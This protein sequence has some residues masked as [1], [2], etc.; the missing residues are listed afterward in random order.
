MEPL[1]PA[2]SRFQAWA[3]ATAGLHALMRGASYLAVEASAE[4][5]PIL[6]RLGFMPLSTLA[7]YEKHID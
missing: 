3:G 7:F 4:S 2:S 1:A 6:E 5:K